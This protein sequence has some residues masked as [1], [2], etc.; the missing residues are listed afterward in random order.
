VPW[1]REDR[2]VGVL[3]IVP[4]VDNKKKNCESSVVKIQKLI[5]GKQQGQIM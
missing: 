2:E 4:S 1:Q 5:K 3:R